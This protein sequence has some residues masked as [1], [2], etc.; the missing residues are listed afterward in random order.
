[1]HTMGGPGFGT[2]NRPY[3]NSGSFSMSNPAMVG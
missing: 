3:V 1:V 2:P